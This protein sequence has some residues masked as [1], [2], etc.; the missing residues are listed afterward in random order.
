MPVAIPGH[1][2]N[3]TLQVGWVVGLVGWEPDICCPTM[4]GGS[5]SSRFHRCN[6]RQHGGFERLSREEDGYLLLK[7]F[8]RTIL[9]SGWSGNWRMSAGKLVPV[10]GH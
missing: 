4:S 10:F 9:S 6:G 1:T 7:P 5:G 8:E 3:E 2:F